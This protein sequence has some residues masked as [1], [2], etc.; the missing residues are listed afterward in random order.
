MCTCSISNILHQRGR[1]LRSHW[2]TSH[3]SCSYFTSASKHRAL[4]ESFSH[5]FVFVFCAATGRCDTL[6]LQCLTNVQ[7]LRKP[8]AS[9]L[10]MMFPCN[11][12][13]IILY[14][15]IKW[16][17]SCES[18]VQW[19]NTV[20]SCISC[21]HVTLSFASLNC[22]TTC[23]HVSSSTSTPPHLFSWHQSKPSHPFLSNFTCVS[24]TENLIFRTR[25]L[26]SQQISVTHSLT[27]ITSTPSTHSTLSGSKMIWKRSN[28]LEGNKY[29]HHHNH[30]RLVI[31]K[32]Q[33][34]NTL[35]TVSDDRE[36]R[37]HKQKTEKRIF[38][39]DS[40]RVFH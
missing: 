22:Y 32:Q 5:S 10:V 27:V 39:N 29:L 16:H 26:S 11:F 33:P 2:S 38:W 30:K 4:F 28:S 8:T 3:V 23:L 31:K 17:H 19:N 40:E 9:Q 14:I 21:L 15:D 13:R 35:K 36:T 24:L 25:F 7:L 12:L 20:A 34:L 6:H 1:T 18:A 37:W